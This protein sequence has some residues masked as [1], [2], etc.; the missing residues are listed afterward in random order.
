MSTSTSDCNAY[1]ET[2]LRAATDDQFFAI[3]KRDPTYNL[4]LEHVSPE[5]GQAYLDK[6]AEFP[7]GGRR[8]LGLAAL[9]DRL[10]DPRVSTYRGMTISP[11]TLRYCKVTEDLRHYF[12]SL[13]GFRIAEIGAGYGGQYTV[14]SRMWEPASYT[15]ID[16]PETVELIRRYV[17]ACRQ[18][19]DY[20]TIPTT[21]LTYL[22]WEEL[23][24]RPPECF[25]LCISNYAFSEVNTGLQDE[26]IERVLGLSHHG[27]ITHNHFD[28]HPVSQLS[29][30]LRT[31]Y[32]HAVQIIDEDPQTGSNNQILIW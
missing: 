28:G 29:D 27:Y 8:L 5:Q 26:Y 7:D 3:F 12:G 19:P 1:R 6:L 18:L 14:L 4:I 9:N 25:D 32:G 23:L 11:S 30:I 15:F 13:D 2:C 24:S 20:G 21:R 17:T 22:P 31:D 16:L 10:G